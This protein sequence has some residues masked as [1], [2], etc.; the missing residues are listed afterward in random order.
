MEKLEY[1]K[2]L[3]GISERGYHLISSVD[4]RIVSVCNS[5]EKDHGIDSKPK[6]NKDE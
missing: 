6:E 4:R 1:L 3:L 5:I 2:V